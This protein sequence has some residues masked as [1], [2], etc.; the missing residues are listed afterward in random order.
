MLQLRFTINGDVVLARALSR[1]GEGI[2]DFS[3][4]LDQIE[5]DFAVI[6]EQQFASEGARGGT[7]W[8]P[9][10]PTY[11]AWK[12]TH[13]PGMPILQATM[14][15]WGQLA[16]GTGMRVERSPRRLLMEPTVPYARWHQTGTRRMPAR[17]PVVLIEE[18]KRRWVRFIYNHVYDE[19]RRQHLI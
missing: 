7:P 3:K 15:L 11:E 16:V 9:L 10:S 8:P 5:V 1:F 4:P 18:D 6:E 17:P 19:G 14:N 13:F 2:A 12:A